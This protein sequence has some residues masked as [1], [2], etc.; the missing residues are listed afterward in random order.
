MPV[1]ARQRKWV[2]HVVVCVKMVPDTTQVKVDPVTNTLVREG[3]PFITNPF[4]DHAVEAALGLKDRFGAKV[5]VLSM[6]PLPAEVVIRKAIARG[7][8]AGILISDRAFG[9]SDTLATSR[10]LAGAISH[11]S[12]QD[13]VSL[14]ICGKQTI[15]GDTAQVGPGIATRLSYSQIT[16]VDRIVAMRP[17]EGTMVAR[18][19]FDD[20][21]E[22]IEARLPAVITVIREMNVPRYP[23]VHG[24]LYAE[25]AEVSVWNNGVLKLDPKVT[26]LN[27]SPTFVKRIFAPPKKVGEVIR[28]FNG[29][30]QK[31]IAKIQTKLDEWNIGHWNC[32]GETQN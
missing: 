32:K 5:T 22:V 13:P 21:Y 9:G 19:K 24:R 29:D 27:G 14:V 10:V 1:F 20:R 12:E 16:L 8:D 17:D 26:G 6:G 7:A 28:G 25:V 18:A 11:L 31:A 3:I 15:D 30:H 2:M 23:S 4:D